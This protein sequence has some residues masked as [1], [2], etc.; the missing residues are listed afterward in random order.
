MSRHQKFLK[1]ILLTPIIL[2]SFL[3]LSASCKK[4]Q[5]EPL[6]L[7]NK[8]GTWIWKLDKITDKHIDFAYKNNVKEVYL[9]IPKINE[10]AKNIIK[11]FKDKNIKV[12]LLLGRKEWIYNISEVEN[13]INWF[14]ELQQKY[15]YF[16][17][18]HFDI[19]PHQY[20]EFK[21]SSEKRKE[22]LIKF[23][24]L[25]YKLKTKFSN[26]KF[27]YDI[28]FWFNDLINFNNTEK[29]A[30]KHIIDLA[31]KIYVMA[32]RNSSQGILK[33]SKNIRE[34]AQKNNKEIGIAVNTKINNEEITSFGNKSKLFMNNELNLLSK[35]IENKNSIAIH[36]LDSWFNLK[37]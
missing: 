21:N 7:P 30:Y 6:N 24:N 33:I 4:R 28:P 17:G 8:L 20:P 16:E 34:Y 18:I 22:Y 15:S 27:H 2:P 14:I 36:H 10:H 12:F 19:E 32:Y 26:I 29:E 23:I 9:N 3:T 13:K 35:N 31:D 5:I 25:I 11:K 37:D 1:C